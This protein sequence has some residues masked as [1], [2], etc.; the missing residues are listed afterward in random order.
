MTMINYHILSP[1]FGT[2]LPSCGIDE[3]KCDISVD[4]L[5]YWGIIKFRIL[6]VA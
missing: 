3:R 6:M 5:D 2:L 1:V 4:T